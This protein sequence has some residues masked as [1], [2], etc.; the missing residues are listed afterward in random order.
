MDED[1]REIVEVGRREEQRMLKAF[2]SKL[3]AA[4]RVRFAVALS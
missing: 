4:A 1:R 3:W 2:A